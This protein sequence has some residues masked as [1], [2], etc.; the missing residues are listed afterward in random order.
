MKAKRRRKSN[1][2]E[3]LSSRPTLT[4]CSP[5]LTL[6]EDRLWRKDFF[7]KITFNP[8]SAMLES[9]VVTAANSLNH[10]H[11]YLN[12]TLFGAGRWKGKFHV[13]QRSGGG[14]SLSEAFINSRVA[15]LSS[16]QTMFRR[17][18]TRVLYLDSD[19]LVLK[20]IL[21]SSIAPFLDS[22]SNAWDE[23]CDLYVQRPSSRGFILNGGVIIA[24]RFRSKPILRKWKQKLL[25]KMKNYTHDQDAFKDL[26]LE[27]GMT[28]KQQNKNSFCYLPN[29]VGYADSFTQFENRFLWLA[30]LHSCTFYHFK[31][32]GVHGSRSNRNKIF[33][34]EMCSQKKWPCLY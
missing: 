6:F 25:M 13:E 4:Q 5:A 30:G 2:E 24:D 26:Q 7:K 3:M 27:N 10:Y 11:K 12:L 15:K 33:M 16:F 1:P 14:N 34:E 17:G 29:D 23:N 32:S 21:D 28:S 18:Y 31:E 8:N 19:I 9:A 22:K 20:P